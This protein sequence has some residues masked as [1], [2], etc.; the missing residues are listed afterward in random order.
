[1]GMIPPTGECEMTKRFV[2]Y[3]WTVEAL[4]EHGDI[5]DVHFWDEAELS[6][7]LAFLASA[8]DAH[9]IGLLRRVVVTECANEN[10]RDDPTTDEE[11]RDY[12]YPATDGKLPPACDFGATVP[13]RFRK[14][15]L[16][17]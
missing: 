12:A 9:R 14:L 5:Q 8:G 1:M 7:A 15:C 16:T 2:D 17:Q 6:Q 10:W 13:A 4:D 11:S 3:E